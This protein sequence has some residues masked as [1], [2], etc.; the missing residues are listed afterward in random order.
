MS[1]KFFL[2]N[3]EMVH[4]V[5]LNQNFK[6][7]VKVKGQAIEECDGWIGHGA[8]LVSRRIWFHFNKIHI[9]LVI[10]LLIMSSRAFIHKNQG[11]L[12]LCSII[13]S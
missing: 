8:Y 12:L 10:E 5:P 11:K 4:M 2:E 1:C 13:E 9:L 3:H 7:K 6:V